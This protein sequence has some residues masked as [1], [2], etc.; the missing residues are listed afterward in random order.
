MPKV[1][2]RSGSGDRQGDTR[3]RSR[4]TNGEPISAQIFGTL[5]QRILKNEYARSGMLPPELTLM[6]EFKVSRHTIRA[7]LQKLVTDGLIE[8]RRGTGTTI[9][10]RDPPQGS[11]AIGSLDQVLGGVSP[12]EVLFAGPVPASEYPRIAEI[13]GV[14]AKETVFQV[15]RLLQSPRGPVSYSTVFTRM[16]FGTRVPKEL[17]ATQLFLT[18][19]EKHC[20][21]RATRA[22][23]VTSAAL[24]PP[25]A[26]RALGVHEL[27]PVLVLQRTFMSRSGEPIEHVDMYC[28][29]DTYAQIVDFY[30]DDVMAAAGGNGRAESDA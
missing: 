12:G 8:R 22:R 4:R 19:L 30:R 1:T 28:R 29:S 9:V 14:T 15:I 21:L 16:E 18:L 27:D 25:A 10:Q 3:K 24:P 7:A 13:F 26:Q 23:Q 2:R 5:R 20:G 11:W 17:I 6:S